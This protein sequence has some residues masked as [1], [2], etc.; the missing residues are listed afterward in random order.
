MGLLDRLFGGSSATRREIRPVLAGHPEIGPLIQSLT[1]KMDVAPARKLFAASRDRWN[2]RWLVVTAV[3]EHYVG[4]LPDTSRAEMM[5]AWIGKTPDEALG[6]LARALA[7]V[8]DAWKARGRGPAGGVPT[9][10]HARFARHMQATIADLQRA[11]QLEPEDPTPHYIMMAT[12]P[13]LHDGDRARDAVMRHHEDVLARAPDHHAAHRRL[14]FLM[15]ERWFGSHRESLDLAKRLSAKAPEG[16]EL[17][18]LVFSAHEYARSYIHFFTKD[19]AAARAYTE[20][21]EVSQDV[22]LAY[23]RSLGSPQHTPGDLTPYRRHEAA[24]WFWVTGDKTRTRL[25]LERVGDLFDADED[26][27]HVSVDRFKAIRK[28]V[29]L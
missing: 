13:G 17:P 5:N 1:A 12:A 24:L 14:V 28:Q 10:S 25:E 11:A 23:A 26:P 4:K 15:S 22:D 29:G 9:D 7:N 18:M 16:S 19:E 2:L 27:W 3:S 21:L 6:Y 20:R 8:D